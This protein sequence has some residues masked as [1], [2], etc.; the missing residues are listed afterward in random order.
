[1][2]TAVIH[3][4]KYIFKNTCI[5]YALF[6]EYSCPYE[7]FTHV[8]IESCISHCLTCNLEVVMH[9]GK[10]IFMISFT[11][12]GNRDIDVINKVL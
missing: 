3:V 11:L 6:V 7:Q 5:E 2:G 1:M 10:T 9:L 12:P 8:E 4:E